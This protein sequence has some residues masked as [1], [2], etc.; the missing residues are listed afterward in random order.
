MVETARPLL[1]LD[2]AM[3]LI[4]IADPVGGAVV[5]RGLIFFALG[6]SGREGG[7]AGK[8][9]R[10]TLPFS[11][12]DLALISNFKLQGR[13]LDPTSSMLTHALQRFTNLN[14]LITAWI[15]YSSFVRSLSLSPM[16]STLPISSSSS[17]S[18]PKSSKNAGPFPYNQ[19]ASGRLRPIL[20]TNKAHHKQTSA[21]GMTQEFCKS[22]AFA[23]SNIC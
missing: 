10:A 2:R 18:F 5:V 3:V 7:C 12:G 17:V 6:M 1:F 9:P 11:V 21:A 23:N 19:P 4:L 16:P 20:S 22:F 13:T 8:F 14:R 15:R